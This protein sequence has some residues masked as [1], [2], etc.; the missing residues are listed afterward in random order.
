MVHFYFAGCFLPKR[1]RAAQD[2]AQAVRWRS[3]R[4]ACGGGQR[5]WGQKAAG[6]VPLHVT[7][8]SNII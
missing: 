6:G 5:V 7:R 2:A 4:G 8:M 3:G 1:A